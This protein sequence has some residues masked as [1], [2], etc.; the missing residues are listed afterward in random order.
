M[1]LGDHAARHNIPNQMINNAQ[2]PRYKEILVKGRT[3]KLKYCFT[4]S[5]I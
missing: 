4:V 1:N 2:M 3:V 5:L